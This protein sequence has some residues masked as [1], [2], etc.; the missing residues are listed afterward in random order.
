MKIYRAAIVGCGKIGSDFAD[1]PRIKDIYTHAGAYTAC[2]RTELIAVCDMDPIKAQRCA[3]RWGICDNYSNM[4]DLLSDKNPEV[5]SI[6]TPD[7]THYGLIR[8]ALRH[9]SVLAV[10][11][12]K[13]LALTIKEAAKLI[14]LAQKNKKI[15]AV[16]YSRRYAKNFQDLKKILDTGT[17]GEIQGVSGYYGKG[18]F[19]SGTHWF[20]LAR[21][22]FGEIA[23]IRGFNRLN[24]GGEDP[25]L[26]VH[27]RFDAGFYAYLHGCS[28]RAFSIFEMDIIGTTGRVSVFN[29]GHTIRF[30]DV[31]D[32]PYYSNYHTL[33]ERSVREGGMENMLLHA[34]E[35]LVDC[36]DNNQTP[37]CSGN[38]G[39]NA[40]KIACTAL[41]SA[42]QGKMLSMR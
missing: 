25:T 14:D 10:L 19:H 15:L 26:D 20:D 12:E 32:S 24:E 22:L 5:I 3:N 31:T 17:I 13:P 11:A 34:V 38:D 28:E 41:S 40:L 35:D 23:S 36:L 33:H 1:D 9:P 30:Y 29:S 8:T 18:V 37:R 16:N 2:K 6:C 4:E 7:S 39:I 21:Y 27:L 42:H